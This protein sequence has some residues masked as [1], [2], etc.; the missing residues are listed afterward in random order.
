MLDDATRGMVSVWIGVTA[1]T[2]DEF[3]AYTKDMERLDSGSPIQR[4]FQSGFI[5]SDW[6]VAYGTAGGRIVPVEE[7]CKEVDCS[8]ATEK[9]IVER[10]HALGVREAN[11]LYYYVNCTFTE[12]RPGML[13]NDL[14]FIGSFDDDALE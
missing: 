11:A 2:L 3:N 10:C 6:F 7:I 14:R 13:Y 9:R 1:K 12:E 5:D 8:L 4:D